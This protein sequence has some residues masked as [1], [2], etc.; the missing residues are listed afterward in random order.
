MISLQAGRASTKLADMR[1]NFVSAVTHELKTP[2]ANLRA[3]HETLAS[4]RAT[5]EMSREYAAMGIRESNRLARLVDNLLAYATD[6]RRR[7]RLRVRTGLARDGVDRS[8]KEFAP[9]LTQ[10]D[11]D[12]Q[13]ELPER[14]PPVLGD[15][16]ALNL[17]LNNLL[18]NAIRYSKNSRQV[19]I[20]GRVDQNDR[21]ARS[22]RQRC[23]HSARR[24]RTCHEEVLARPEFSDKRKRPRAGD[25]RSHRHRSSRGNGDSQHGRRGNVRDHHASGSGVI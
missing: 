25:C 22:D 17:M 3:I 18:D 14:L 12:M 16:T 2:I 4:G 9:N 10:G 15:P 24:N 13:V 7:A 21:D 11:F 1:S 20:A 6:H 5:I 19:T 8:V 23:R